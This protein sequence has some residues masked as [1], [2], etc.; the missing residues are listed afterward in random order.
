MVFTSKPNSAYAKP[1]RLYADASFHES[2][3]CKQLQE[4]VAGAMTSCRN[5]TLV[6]RDG[7]ENGEA[8][9]HVL[10]RDVHDRCDITAAVAVVGCGPD[11]YYRLLRKMELPIVS[12]MQ[13]IARIETHLIAFIY[14]LMGTSD[15]S[16]IIDLVELL[17]NLVP[18]QP[19]CTT[20]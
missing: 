15:Q 4:V 3:I 11:G 5:G 9:L 1:K 19:A 14:K 16:Q 12:N 7:L 8:G 18:K 17:S 20:R 10:S 2:S 6:L 13:E